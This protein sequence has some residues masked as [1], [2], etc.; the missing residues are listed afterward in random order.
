MLK[1]NTTAAAVI[2]IILSIFAFIFNIFAFYLFL[3]VGAFVNL[4]TGENAWLID[5]V[6]G[7]VGVMVILAIILFAIS[8]AVAVKTKKAQDFITTKK[9]L[10]VYMI[11]A[12]IAILINLFTGILII[13]SLIGWLYILFALI[14]VLGM[15]LTIGDMTKNSKLAAT[16][17]N[18]ESK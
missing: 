18:E 1:K 2:S 3:I 6:L 8:I 14:Y 4:G 12:G 17:R 11:F 16:E 7:L 5:M 9:L 10:I 15:G 13:D